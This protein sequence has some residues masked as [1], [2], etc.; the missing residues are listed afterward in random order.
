MV[1]VSLT[2]THCYR[3]APNLQTTYT[4]LLRIITLSN[5][6]SYRKMES[7]RNRCVRSLNNAAWQELSHDSK[8]CK[9]R[10]DLTFFWYVAGML[11][12]I[13][14][15]LILFSSL[16]ILI[17]LI[18]RVF[19]RWKLRQCRRWSSSTTTGR[20]RATTRSGRRIMCWTSAKPPASMR[21][22]KNW[23]VG[24]AV[25]NYV[26]FGVYFVLLKACIVFSA[27]TVIAQY[28]EETSN[29][30][31][32]LRIHYK[33]QLLCVCVLFPIIERGRDANIAQQSTK[34]TLLGWSDRVWGPAA[35]R[36]KL[37]Q[38]VTLPLVQEL[39]AP[40]HHLGAYPVP[41]L[42]QLCAQGY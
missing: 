11:V 37:A 33:A 4:Q 10:I 27:V 9:C 42:R 24:S 36:S 21:I 8:I 2:K 1:A 14:N 38:R 5:S 15:H 34:V 3:W 20:R 7:Y 30:S 31:C 19:R 39:P 22:N 16:I 12:L 28:V 29:L 17:C 35:L 13:V 26:I 18:M 23:N 25:F 32:H 40:L 6:Y 41:R